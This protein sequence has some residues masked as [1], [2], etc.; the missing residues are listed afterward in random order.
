MALPKVLAGPLLR[1]VADS[2]VTVWVAL[3]EPARV[4]LTVWPGIQRSAGP[5]AV[6]SGTPSVATGSAPTRRFGANF[7]VAV[8]VAK[9]EGTTVAPGTIHS[10]DLVIDGA[11]LLSLGLLQDE[12]PGARLEGVDPSA[13][14]HLALGYE[15]D[16]LPTF[17][18]AAPLLADLC[19]AHAS[20]RRTNFGR[21]QRLTTPGDP[22]DPVP[23]EGPDA[24]AYLDDII[25]EDE[26]TRSG[27]RSSCSSLATR[28]TPTISAPACWRSSTPSASSCSASPSRCPSPTRRSRSR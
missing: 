10:Y 21:S 11:N 24:M 12:Q 6:D 13:P 15:L 26:A 20:C 7:H 23:Q 4:T 2:S 3:R 22:E 28:S 14:L 9:A 16:R 19:L 5:G 8:V 18:T 17:A 27:A 1:R 25:E